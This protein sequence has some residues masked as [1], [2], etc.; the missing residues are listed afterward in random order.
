MGRDTDA[1]LQLVCVDASFLSRCDSEHASGPIT[2]VRPIACDKPESQQALSEEVVSLSDRTAELAL[3]CDTI[4]AVDRR[5]YLGRASDIQM[6]ERHEALDELD[7]QQ[8]RSDLHELHTQRISYSGHDAD[9]CDV[10]RPP[11]FNWL[12]IVANPSHSW[13]AYMA[14]SSLLVSSIE[15][16][17][18]ASDVW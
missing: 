8:V 18:A 11:Y 3:S 5:L 9:H 6:C 17:S 10:A 1:G 13:H 15:M 4:S 7:F 16:V 2:D 14:S 12:D